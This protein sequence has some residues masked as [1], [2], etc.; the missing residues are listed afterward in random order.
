MVLSYN[1]LPLIEDDKP[2]STENDNLP[3]IEEESSDYDSLPLIED[4]KNFS[5]LKKLGVEKP[6]DFNPKQPSF[7]LEKSFV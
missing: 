6:K 1:S 5:L 7:D 4:D 2:E 3:L